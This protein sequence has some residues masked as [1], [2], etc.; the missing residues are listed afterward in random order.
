[1]K[2]K[3]IINKNIILVSMETA[4]ILDFFK[5]FSTFGSYGSHVI[6]CFKLITAIVDICMCIMSEGNLNQN[7]NKMFVICFKILFFNRSSFK[8]RYNCNG[9]TY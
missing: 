7:K 8:V 2:R 9:E 4:G 3:I 6:L 1:M 5:Y